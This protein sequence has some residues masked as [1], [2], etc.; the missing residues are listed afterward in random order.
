MGT[1]DMDCEKC[2]YY[3]KALTRCNRAPF[4][5]GEADCSYRELNRTEGIFC[6]DCRAFLEMSNRPGDHSTCLRYNHE[7]LMW[8]IDEYKIKY[9]KC[10]Q[11]LEE[12]QK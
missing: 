1:C 8:V 3:N 4:L 7:R 9:K 11:C 2:Q 6:D 10:K 12:V 5:N